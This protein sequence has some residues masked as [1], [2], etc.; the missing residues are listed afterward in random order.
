MNRRRHLSTQNDAAQPALPPAGVPNHDA[1]PLP[2]CVMHKAPHVDALAWLSRTLRCVEEVAPPPYQHFKD[3][4]AT[5]K[6]QTFD[7]IDQC[8]KIATT[9]LALAPLA[10]TGLRELVVNAVEHGNLEIDFDQKS[11]LLATGKWQDEIESR[12]ANAAFCDR[13]ASVELMRDDSTFTI[14]V[15]D[16][17]PGFDWRKH[18][19]PDTAPRHMLHGRGMSLAMVAGLGDI[20]YDGSGNRVTIRGVCDPDQQT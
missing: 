15:T 1:L 2:G 20:Q 14:R 13:I 9:V 16:Q 11:E 18:L 4:H 12:L 19:D 6:V 3:F 8:I 7:D 10:T 17:G 5:L